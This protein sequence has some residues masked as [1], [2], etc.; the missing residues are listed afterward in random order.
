MG[1]IVNAPDANQV[2]P[3]FKTTVRSSGRLFFSGTH[4]FPI[5]K[6]LGTVRGRKCWDETSARLFPGRVEVRNGTP[7]LTKIRKPGL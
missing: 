3:F 4:V 5:A 2:P 7:A 1:N 6:I